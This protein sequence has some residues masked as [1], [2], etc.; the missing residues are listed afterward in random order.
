MACMLNFIWSATMVGN[1]LYMNNDYF[2]FVSDTHYLHID[3]YWWGVHN[4]WLIC[5]TCVPYCILLKI[6]CLWVGKGKTLTLNL[7]VVNINYIGGD[8]LQVMFKMISL[9]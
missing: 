2:L 4:D 9:I 6:Y 5:G 1:K 8:V 7:N 3:H